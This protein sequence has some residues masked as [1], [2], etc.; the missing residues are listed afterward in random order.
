MRLH[1][2]T[3]VRRPLRT[4]L[5]GLAVATAGGL[6]ALIGTAGATQSSGTSSTVLSRT[7]LA[8]PVTVA[9]HGVRLRTRGPTQVV[10]QH[11][12]FQPGGTSGWHTHPGAVLVSVV[13]GE[14]TVYGPDCAPK[15]FAAGQAY[16]EDADPVLVRN[17]GAVVAEA[18]VTFL[19]P[20][21]SPLRFDVPVSP[22]PGVG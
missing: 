18:Q 19:A 17:E 20:S 6:G 1:K 11:T 13:A 3:A 8:D 9:N 5:V 10:D 12:V 21:E 14:F 4:W 2:S 7:T 22:C 15:R 16:V